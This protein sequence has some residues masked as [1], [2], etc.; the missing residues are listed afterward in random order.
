MTQ[1]MPGVLARVLDILAP[2]SICQRPMAGPPRA[3][4]CRSL[5]ALSILRVGDE[6]LRVSSEGANREKKRPR[7]LW[8]RYVVVSGRA[9]DTNLRATAGSVTKSYGLTRRFARERRMKGGQHGI[10]T[11]S[12]VKA[13]APHTR[14]STAVRTHRPGWYVPKF[15]TRYTV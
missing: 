15:N 11:S 12:V 2:G 8:E 9:H 3:K 10:G 6:N 4:A 7:A 13:A 14:R 5:L 1:S